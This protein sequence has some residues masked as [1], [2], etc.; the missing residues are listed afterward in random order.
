MENP[1]TSEVLITFIGGPL[2]GTFTR[3]ADPP[4]L[5]PARAGERTVLYVRRWNLTLTEGTAVFAPLGMT[6]D[7]IEEQARSL[8]PS[9]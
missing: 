5:I 1:A 2:H 8:P 7:A 6:D 4:D 3:R 9:H